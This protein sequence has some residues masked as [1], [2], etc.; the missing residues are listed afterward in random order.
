MIAQIHR[1]D[2]CAF[3]LK[4]NSAELKGVRCGEGKGGEAKKG[5]EPVKEAKIHCE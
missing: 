1:A 5:K 4:E 2:R 3:S